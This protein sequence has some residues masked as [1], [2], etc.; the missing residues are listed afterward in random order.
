MRL[1]LALNKAQRIFHAD[2]V[3]RTRLVV[4][5]HSVALVGRVHDFR[6]ESRADELRARLVGDG[7]Q[8]RRDGRTILRVQVGVDLV[9]DDHG[10]AFCLLQGKNQAQGTQTW[11]GLV[12]D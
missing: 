3:H 2:T 12:I 8:Q 1:G 11:K 4:E 7:L 10:T 5:R 6:T 9:K